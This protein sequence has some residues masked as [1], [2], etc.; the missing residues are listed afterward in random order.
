ALAIAGTDDSSAHLAA[1]ILNSVTGNFGKTIMFF[2]GSPAEETS[3]PDEVDAAID[4]MRGGEIDAVFIAGGN[5][6]FTMPASARIAEALQKV[7]LVVWA[8]GVPD[9]TAAMANLIL[10]AHHPLESW[11]DTAPRSGIRG[12][13]QPVMQPVFDSKPV[14]DIL[15]AAAAKSSSAKIP[16]A[17]TA[18]A[19]KAEWLALASKA[20]STDPK[21]FWTKVRR[22]GG[23]IE[24]PVLVE[25]TVRPGVIAVPIG[26]GHRAYGRY[27][28]DVG[29]NAWAI[30]AAGATYAAVIARATG[31]KRKLVSPLGKRD[32]MGRSIVE[33]MSIEQ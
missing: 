28:K 23:L 6:V 2:E 25:S 16:W 20:D 14:G 11:R 24:A 13:G 17:N 31:E 21:D 10:P 32:M 19:V 12:L 15:L 7:P 27:A 9:E 30:L 8:G 18:E 5:P 33:A 3:T 4:A 26:Q 22:E 1:M 29:A